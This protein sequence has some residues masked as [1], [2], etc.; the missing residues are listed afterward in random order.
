[1][2]KAI[3]L[4]VQFAERMFRLFAERGERFDLLASG[5]YNLKKDDVEEALKKVECDGNVIDTFHMH[6]VEKKHLLGQEIEPA[7]RGI[8]GGGA[9]RA[10]SAGQ[11]LA[12][13]L[14]DGIVGLTTRHGISQAVHVSL[15]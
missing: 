10:V 9:R 14:T 4:A 13:L 2:T 5:D 12:H 15:T 1:M 6:C 11:M 8:L 3:D 7:K